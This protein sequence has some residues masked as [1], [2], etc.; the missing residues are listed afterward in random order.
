MIV[1]LGGSFIN[2]SQPLFYCNRNFFYMNWQTQHGLNIVNGAH[3]YIP[4]TRIIYQH[5][6]N[7]IPNPLALQWLKD[8]GITLLAFHKHMT[9]P[10]E[11]VLLTSLENSP[12]LDKVF[13]GKK[14]VFFRF[15]TVT[16]N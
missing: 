5:Y 10:R 12:L 4:Y 6:I 7:L 16:V 14:E 1:Q 13:E 8:K 11:E 3:G 15:K 9:L 2:D